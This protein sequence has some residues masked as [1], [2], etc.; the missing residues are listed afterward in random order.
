MII[1]IKIL[2]II[3]QRAVMS[4][5]SSFLTTIG[6][7][8]L[9]GLAVDAIGKKTR[10]PR[11]TLLIIFGV[12][13]GEGVFDLIPNF[14]SDNFEIIADMVLLMV[15][16]LI[17]GK[18]NIDFLK[19]TGKQS[20]II[21]LVAA[22]ITTLIVSLGLYSLGVDLG[23]AVI[24]GCIASATAPAAIIDIILENNY[25]SKFSKLLLSVVALDDAWGL[26]MFSF[27]LAF[28]SVLLG[29]S[30]HIN[31]AISAFK[32]IGG[33]LLL[34]IVIGLPASYLTGRIRDGQPILME[35][36]GLVFLL[37]GISIFFEVSFLIS[38]ITMGFIVSNFATHHDYPFHAI[39]G[40]EWPFMSI[41][42]VLA[43]ATL[44]IEALLSI[45][46]A[47][48]LYIVLRTIGKIAGTYIGVSLSKGDRL[49][50]KYL[51]T[52]MLPQAGVPIGMALVASNL[53][54]Q[55]EQL[56]LHIVIA[57]TVFFELVGPIYVK[58]ALD[59]SLVDLF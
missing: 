6:I 42:F 16:F 4:N 25:D 49:T 29:D 3:K 11:V 32:E 19:Q 5:E 55:Y 53:F 18:L 50:Q 17:G 41:F 59:K 57:S 13:I 37:G 35:A 33:A 10:L 7:I 12:I 58:K 27:G 20:F 46:Y 56:I 48:V 23:V 24:L 14:I 51:G 1:V 34:G 9:V 38:A 31:L 43:G 2:R 40:I 54:P 22:V 36:L 47:G 28:V 45:G 44:N 52:A 21:S 8:L 39:E 30:S 15:G 26:I